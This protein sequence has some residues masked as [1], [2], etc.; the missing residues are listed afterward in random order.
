MRDDSALHGIDSTGKAEAAQKMNVTA[1]KKLLLVEDQKVISIVEAQVIK[2]NG[3]EVTTVSSGEDSVEAVKTDPSI[4][5][6]LMDIELGEG[7]DGT[8]AAR[9]ILE[10][11]SLPIVFLTSHSE[12]EMVEKVRGITR[13]GY[14]IKNSGDFVLLSS[15][16]MALELFY[17]H[18][19]TEEHRQD[20]E[21]HQV[22]L[23][24]Q[25]EELEYASRELEM[26]HEE[27]QDLYERAP[28]GYITLNGKL[29]ITKANIT[30][31][32]L[33][34]VGRE[35]LR[36]QALLGWVVKED[37]TVYY[38]HL[39]TL[40]K[41]GIPKIFEV[42]MNR[43][44]GSLLWVSMHAVRS[45]HENIV[46]CR[47]AITDITGRREAEE[48]NRELLEEHR[49]IADLLLLIGSRGEDLRS[50][51]KEITLRLQ[52][53]SQ[54]DAVGVR[55]REGE[56]F[57]YYE[58]RGFSAE[59]L[60]VERYLCARDRQGMLILDSAGQP[61]LECMCGNILCGRFDPS[62]PFFTQNG[63]F[64]T[65]CTTELLAST[66]EKDRM[67]R[68]RNRC[69]GEGYES[70]AII[71]LRTG[72]TTFGLIQ[73]N[74]FSRNRFTPDRITLF[75]SLASSISETLAHRQAQLEL[76]KSEERYRSYV[77]SAPDGV[78]IVDERGNYREVNSA[79]SVIT[80]YSREELL[81]MNIGDLIHPEDREK[82][83]THFQHTATAGSA[84][85]DLRFIAKGGEERWWSVDAVKIN[86]TELIGF[87]KDIS[88]R[89][90]LE[91]S[92]RN[93]AKFPDENPNPT[94]RLSNEC[95]LQYANKAA[96]SLFC[97]ED[98]RISELVL[99]HWRK[100]I[101]NAVT[102]KK[103]QYGEIEYDK[104]L[105]SFNIVPIDGEGYCNIYGRDI[106]ER[107]RVEDAL[108][109]NEEKFRLI[110]ETI[111]EV[112]W[113]A[114]SKIQ[115][116]LYISPGYERIWGCSRESLYE[117]PR[118]FIDAIHPMDR[119]RVLS[120][121]ALQEKGL[122][123]AHEYR[124]VRP[125]G[126]F[127]WIYDRGFPVFSQAGAIDY[128]GIAID[129]TERKLAEEELQLHSQIISNLESG[130]I[131]VRALDGVIVYTNPKFE[132]IF[133]YSPGEMIGKH[134]A[135]VNAPSDKSPQETSKEIIEALNRDG[136]WTGEVYN[137]R[138]DGTPFWC[139][140]TVSTFEHSRYETVWVT[141][142][143][144]ITE[145]K[146]IEDALRESE[147][148]FSQF[149][150]HS[151]VIVYIKDENLRL[152]KLSKNFED[153]LG[154][155]ISELL[156]KDSY[157]HL[158]LEFAK[159]A[160]SDDLST[161]KEG[162]IIES[163]EKLNNRTYSTIK[164]PIRRGAGKSDYIGGFSVDIT[165]RKEAEERVKSLLAE[166]ELLLQ[167]V[168][169]RIKNNMGI[170][171]NLLS[172]QSHTLEDPAAVAALMDARS[173]I[174]CME[175]LYDKLY[176][177]VGF[178]EI[179][180]QDYLPS[181]IDEIVGMFPN[182]GM[183]KIETEIEDFVLG[184][185]VLPPLGILMN[186]LLTNAMKHAF[187]GRDDGLI[188]VSAS[189]KDTHVTLTVEDNGKGI[190]ESIDIAASTGFGLQLVGMLAEQLKG[191][192][193]LERQKGSK[194]I[195]EFEVSLRKEK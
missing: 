167:E 185:K 184:A 12:R 17:A 102:E 98:G 4:D 32:A 65:N 113:I 18:R 5:L 63:G 56:D 161:L 151:P 71:P 78:F 101:S 183:V 95:A 195:L 176:C 97:G 175:V 70:V 145:R 6:V 48:R 174:Q 57:P 96:K 41:T 178:R 144:D 181:L 129:I 157:E 76:Q 2:R 27:Y 84:R 19:R 85:G 24:A 105:Y 141:I 73:F 188:M 108:R 179:S 11:R 68:T 168:H 13:Y 120:N 163:E 111:T 36:G 155:P 1:R 154:K 23:I 45:E 43:K 146:R 107:K 91:E 34:Q 90:Q 122:P 147:E 189:V 135:I 9:R 121:L 126:S 30:I 77:E 125:D 193:R 55:L 22:E 170:M 128:V 187:T 29:Q 171:M 117:N 42:R 114:D 182:K 143:R 75:E 142:Q 127:R 25:S 152:I 50:L 35:D 124:V 131:M 153:L 180:A 186:E 93:L 38:T 106:T 191:T 165:M 138:K 10:I 81:T 89:K 58:T 150:T 118:S 53:W 94:I 112:F 80:G 148:I 156:G 40:I 190:P 16:E 140:A 92:L 28:V 192:I 83:H 39:R 64:W 72:N 33:L 87:A 119:E 46:S 37:E 86:A 44:D 61:E 133:G 7:I 62:K 159:S 110:A 136:C 20:L 162:K 177:S 74:A 8:E 79:A 116:M 49:I 14:V 166:K 164:F 15:I 52:E 160:I 60:D 169:H 82:A 54:C 69:N 172:L 115:K 21:V 149:M 173:R 104:C 99:E 59:F 67:A 137:I 26:S 31:A 47:I 3:Y 100:G 103:S 130:I 194:F 88:E 51:M 109:N 134:V 158:P 123:F 132:K 139:Y 66:T